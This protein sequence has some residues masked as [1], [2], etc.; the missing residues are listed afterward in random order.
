MT[1]Y[2]IPYEQFTIE[3][4]TVIVEFLAMIEDYNQNKK[5]NPYVLSK[6][7]QKYRNIINSIALE[8]QIEKAFEKETGYSVYK[9]I[10]SLK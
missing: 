3:E 10:K 2:P 7:H 4:I 1:N 8:K 5:I 6:K 9:T